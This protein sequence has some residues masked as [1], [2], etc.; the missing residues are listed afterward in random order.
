MIEDMGAKQMI[1]T[2]RFCLLYIGSSYSIF[3]V[4]FQI[5]KTDNDQEHITN[6]QKVRL[7]VFDMDGSGE[8]QL[9]EYYDT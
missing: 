4:Q 5:S 2:L 6:S 9:P 7:I 3:E 1:P 8:L